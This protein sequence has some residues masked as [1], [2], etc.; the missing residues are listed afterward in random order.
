MTTNPILPLGRPMSQS[1]LILSSAAAAGFNYYD[2]PNIGEDLDPCIL[3]GL[4]SAI[5]AFVGVSAVEFLFGNRGLPGIDELFNYWFGGK[6][7]GSPA[8]W[9]TL[10]VAAIS[11]T[12][13]C[14]VVPDNQ[15]L[16]A[17]IV[18][19]AL[20]SNH[21]LQGCFEGNC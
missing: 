20:I 2:V 13:A 4:Q 6:K 8:G 17:G 1:L 5:G 10:S 11:G 9:K 12:L 7:S 15:A 16:Q 14:L 18:F 21:K 3:K 19:V